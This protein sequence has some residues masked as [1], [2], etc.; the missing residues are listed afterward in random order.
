M[1]RF[2]ALSRKIILA[3]LDNPTFDRVSIYAN[4]HGYYV[5][6]LGII[7]TIFFSE[8]KAETACLENM[9]NALICKCQKNDV[10]EIAIKQAEEV[11]DL[12]RLETQYRIQI[13]VFNKR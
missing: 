10:I 12:Y 9:I 11:V 1:L 8:L 4:T 13:W 2:M 3:P 6:T 5:D 7:E